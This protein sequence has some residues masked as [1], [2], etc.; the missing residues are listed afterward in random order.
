MFPVALWE[1]YMFLLEYEQQKVRTEQEKRKVCWQITHWIM[2][3]RREKGTFFS[4]LSDHMTLLLKHRV[5]TI[6]VQPSITALHETVK[7]IGLEYMGMNY[8]RQQ[9]EKIWV[10]TRTPKILITLHNCFTKCFFIGFKSKS[11]PNSPALFAC[12]RTRPLSLGII[13]FTESNVRSR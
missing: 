3:P 11:Q 8:N 2:L 7:F 12:H 4:C 6:N 9:D 5:E 1:K 13:L 10:D